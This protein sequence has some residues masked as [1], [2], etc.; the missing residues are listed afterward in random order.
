MRVN[1]SSGKMHMGIN[2]RFTLEYPLCVKG[3]KSRWFHGFIVGVNDARDSFFTRVHGR[4]G[5]HCSYQRPERCVFCLMVC[6]RICV[7]T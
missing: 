3:Q 7:F 5:G 4:D 6:I 1:V 2:V